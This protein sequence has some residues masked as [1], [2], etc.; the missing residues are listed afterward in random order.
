MNVLT[1][2]L[3]I[4]LSF[5]RAGE[6]T[7]GTA[8]LDLMKKKQKIKPAKILKYCP[9]PIENKSANESSIYEIDKGI[10]DDKAKLIYGI[11]ALFENKEFL[12]PEEISLAI[13]H[14]L[15]I[16]MLNLK[17]LKIS[18]KELDPFRGLEKLFIV[19]EKAVNLEKITPNA[20]VRR[21]FKFYTLVASILNPGEQSTEKGSSII[22]MTSVKMFLLLDEIGKDLFLSSPES[23]DKFKNICSNIKTIL[24][25]IS[26]SFKKQAEEIPF[27]IDFISNNEVPS[28][29][30]VSSEYFSKAVIQKLNDFEEKFKLLMN[31]IND[32]VDKRIC[33]EFY[34][35]IRLCYS[36]AMTLTS[37]IKLS[38][39]IKDYKKFDGTAESSEYNDK[40]S[41]FIF[42]LGINLYMQSI[43]PKRR[44]YIF[45]DICNGWTTKSIELWYK[46]AL[47]DFFFPIGG[48]AAID[49]TDL[50]DLE[51]SNKNLV[52][53]K[54]YIDK[55]I[56]EIQG[57]LK[58][59]DKVAYPE[60]IMIRFANRLMCCANIIN[61]Y[62]LQDKRPECL[63]KISEAKNLL[64]QLRKNWL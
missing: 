37:S 24:T 9:F 31:T 3:M 22:P 48:L 45:D 21:N 17:N 33:S 55:V 2:S 19:Y 44:N 38:L 51:K 43:D 47:L 58:V 10:K 6:M 49:Y 25:E 13:S 27:T 18:E 41:F 35:T 26:D 56:E 42:D 61:K 63:E 53:I 23:F 36:Y 7:F 32:N 34:H 15:K 30:K 4:L 5:L 12:S 62:I 64:N 16:N 57:Y 40:L 39:L 28:S 59:N 8:S 46:N 14:E 52:V 54:E 20:N 1:K 11:K 50:K 60:N 29:K